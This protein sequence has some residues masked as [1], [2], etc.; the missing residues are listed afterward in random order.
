M[1]W[2]ATLVLWL[3]HHFHVVGQH[4]GYSADAVWIDF[5]ALVIWLTF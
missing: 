5:G 1:E 3:G 2:L 4:M